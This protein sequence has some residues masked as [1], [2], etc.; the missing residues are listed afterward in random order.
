LTGGLEEC[1]LGGVVLEP[2]GELARRAGLFETLTARAIEALGRVGDAPRP[3]W[4]FCFR[5][6]HYP[7]TG[8]AS[9]WRSWILFIPGRPDLPSII[10]GLEWARAADRQ[11]ALSD[12][13]LA[14]KRRL[15]L[16]PS[17]TC[18]DGEAID[19]ELAALL[20]AASQL[21]LPALR[22]PSPVGEPLE[23]GLDGWRRLEWSV[24]NELGLPISRWAEQARSLFARCLLR[25]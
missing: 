6:W 13:V 10:R 3:G 21:E 16:E 4:R 7:R 22:W 2:E 12:P 8:E 9:P 24:R 5:L 11:R 1:T 18:R 20:A 17:I 23:F 14:Q 19:D 15:A 25:D